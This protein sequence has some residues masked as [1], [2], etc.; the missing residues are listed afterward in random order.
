MAIA[1]LA[2]PSFHTMLMMLGLPKLALAPT[3]TRGRVKPTLQ[4]LARYPHV[5]IPVPM[6]RT[7]Q[8]APTTHDDAVDTD[9][10]TM[11][12][13]EITSLRKD[14]NKAMRAGKTRLASRR[15]HGTS[16]SLLPVTPEVLEQLAAKHPDRGDDSPFGT[17]RKGPAPSRRVGAADVLTHTFSIN[18]ESSGGISGWTPW[19][20]QYCSTH[21][22]NLDENEAN[23]SKFDE[24]LVKLVALVQRGD[25]PGA[26]L[27]CTSRLVALPK[28]DN[29][30]RPIA[31]GETMYRVVA[32]TLLRTTNAWASALHPNQLGCSTPGGTEPLIRVLENTIQ[33]AQRDGCVDKLYVITLDLENAF[34]SLSRKAIADAVFKYMPELYRAIRWSYGTKSALVIVDVHGNRHVIWSKEGARQ[35]CPYSQVL[36]ALVFMPRFRALVDAAVARSAG[37]ML[38]ADLSDDEEASFQPE[39]KHEN[40]FA[41]QDDIKLITSDGNI[42]SRIAATIG[43]SHVFRDGLSFRVDKT[44]MFPLSHLIHEGHEYLGSAVGSP[45]F[46]KQFLVA[47]VEDVKRR[48][49]LLKFVGKQ[50]ALLL[51]RLSLGAELRHLLRTLAPDGLAP[52]WADLD[53]AFL[54]TALQLAGVDVAGIDHG[55]E[56]G[57][58][59]DFAMPLSPPPSPSPGH[60]FALDS[61][62][63]DSM[64]SD[65][66]PEPVTRREFFIRRAMFSLSLPIK[67][68]GLGVGDH[69]PSMLVA[70]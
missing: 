9:E 17:T 57:E 49:R 68:G 52:V 66:A 58:P 13:A 15:L 61:D 67:H 8:Q 4:R 62:S 2:D 44:D 23:L 27:L 1:F 3:V 63:D 39:R 41:F 22:R 25:C 21:P 43:P 36:F 10:Q 29:S 45:T 50:Q 53:R 59:F 16:Q 24:F 31:I 19:L 11:R 56:A 38:L 46:R 33:G 40:G 42:M 35:G 30:A 26:D 47:K 20:V 65:A 55:P 28:S 12:Y 37:D 70:R 6:P 34:N 14:I 7:A 51:M 54:N 69:Q 18:P 5:N 60:A 32:K 48:L 64:D